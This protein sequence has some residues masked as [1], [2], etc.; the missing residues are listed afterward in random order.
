MGGVPMTTS[1]TYREL[2]TTGTFGRPARRREIAGSRGQG[3]ARRLMLT[4]P[5][6]DV[7]GTPTTFGSIGVLLTT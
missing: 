2:V 3:D 5:R 6:S 7:G 1:Q 4:A